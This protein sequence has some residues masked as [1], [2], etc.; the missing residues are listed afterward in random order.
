MS[1][2]FSPNTHIALVTEGLTEAELMDDR[3]PMSTM[4]ILFPIFVA[5][6]FKLDEDDLFVCA[7]T[8]TKD[9]FVVTVD[10]ATFCGRCKEMLLLE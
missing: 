5:K 3:L 6:T 9:G 8:S 7:R 1:F 10:N 2:V 4:T